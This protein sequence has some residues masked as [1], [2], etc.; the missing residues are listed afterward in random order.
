MDEA[1]TLIF[2]APNEFDAIRSA[3]IL[4]VVARRQVLLAA[5]TAFEP[6]LGSLPIGLAHLMLQVPIG[7]LQRKGQSGRSGT[8][9]GE[10]TAGRGEFVDAVPIV[11][12]YRVMDAEGAVAMM[13]KTVKWQRVGRHLRVQKC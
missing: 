9:A 12:M 8:V 4:P 2:Y 3:R 6:A 5:M 7:R 11:S 10:L 1:L 13:V